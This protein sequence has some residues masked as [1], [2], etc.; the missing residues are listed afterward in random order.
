MAQSTRLLSLGERGGR[1]K[2][3]IPRSRQAYSKEDSELTPAIHLQ[4]PQAPRQFGLLPFPGW[5]PPV[6]GP[7][8]ATFQRAQVPGIIAT[9]Q[10]AKRLPASPEIATGGIHA[11]PMRTVTIEPGQPL[12]R[13]R[14]ARPRHVQMPGP[15]HSFPFGPHRVTLHQMSTIRLNEHIRDRVVPAQGCQTH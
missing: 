11:I 15:E 1:T 9:Q 7:V 5:L 8:R 2:S 4:R 3:W 14:L 13:S 12:A 10:P 6:V